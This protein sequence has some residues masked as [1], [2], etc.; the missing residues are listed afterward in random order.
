MNSPWCGDSRAKHWRSSSA[1]VFFAARPL[2]RPPGSMRSS[3]PIPHP[4]GGAPRAPCGAQSPAAKSRPMS[5]IQTW[6]PGAKRRETH[7]SRGLRPRPH[8]RRAAATS[9]TKKLDTGQTVC[10]WRVDRLP[11]R[12]IGISSGSLRCRRLC[13]RCS[14]PPHT[15]AGHVNE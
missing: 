14:G 10:A 15:G 1:R 9:D 6:R 3:H 13:P 7:L 12:L 5:V 11:H 4:S 8:H 2:G